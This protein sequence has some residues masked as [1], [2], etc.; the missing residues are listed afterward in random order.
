MILKPIHIGLC[1]LM[2]VIT[3]LPLASS[4]VSND[5]GQQNSTVDRKL[6]DY[7]CG[8]T[9]RQPCVHLPYHIE[10]LLNAS[11]QGFCL[12]NQVR[13]HQVR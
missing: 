8:L 10:S 1:M 11:G 13:F 4:S 3:R 5:T 12:V 6:V 9:I 2:S 7:E